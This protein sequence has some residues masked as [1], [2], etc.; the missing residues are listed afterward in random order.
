MTS[1]NAN[2]PV[3]SAGQTYSFRMQAAKD[4]RSQYTVMLKPDQI[5][6]FVTDNSEVVKSEAMLASYSALI[7]KQDREIKAK[8]GKSIW[9]AQSGTNWSKRQLFRISST[10]S[11]P[12]RPH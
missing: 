9:R 3:G 7:E 4:R 10:T 6:G 12:D 2:F 5:L 8:T 11:D 1:M